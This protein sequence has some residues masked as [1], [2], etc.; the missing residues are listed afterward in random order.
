MDAANRSDCQRTI[1]STVLA[2]REP[3]YARWK[4]LLESIDVEGIRAD[5]IVGMAAAMISGLA[6]RS[7]WQDV[8]GLTDSVIKEWKELIEA[9][10]L[11][12]GA[13]DTEQP[14]PR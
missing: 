4:A 12:A 11:A 5:H 8:S 14:S 6:M 10:W 13:R 7:L 9:S 1:K 3:I 2:L